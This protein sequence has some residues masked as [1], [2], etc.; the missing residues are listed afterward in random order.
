MEWRDGYLLPPERPGLGV[1]FDR[2]AARAHPFQMAELR[3]LQRADGS[4]TNW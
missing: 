3:H 4:L 1:E 2:A